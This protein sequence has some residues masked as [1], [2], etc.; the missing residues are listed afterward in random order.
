[1]NSPPASTS[2]AGADA[3]PSESQHSQQLQQLSIAAS[4][5]HQ[6]D[7]Y[8]GLPAMELAEEDVN[9]WKPVADFYLNEEKLG[10][11]PLIC[12]LARKLLAAPCSSVYSERLFSE[13]GLI[14]EKK[15]SCLRPDCAE[16]LLFLHHNMVRFEQYEKEEEAVQKAKRDNKSYDFQYDRLASLIDRRRQEEEADGY[17]DVDEFHGIGMSSSS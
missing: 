2:S 8:L 15:R 4:I 12:Q 14:Y 11:T 13:M 7:T 16:N 5:R 6:I 3:S 10:R 9:E 17:V 1:M